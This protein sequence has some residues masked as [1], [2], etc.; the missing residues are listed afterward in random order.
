MTCNQDVSPG[1]MLT[2]SHTRSSSF[3]KKTLRRTK[4]TFLSSNLSF[5]L[6][7]LHLQAPLLLPSRP[8]RVVS[9]LKRKNKV[10]RF[11]LM[12]YDPQELSAKPLAAKLL[13]LTPVDDSFFELYITKLKLETFSVKDDTI[14]R[15]SVDTLVRLL[16]GEYSE[17]F[18]KVIIVDC[19]FEYEYQ[20]GHIDGSVNVSSQTQL[21]NEF[22][23]ERQNTSERTLMVFHCEFS[24]Y[25]G[26]FM[27]LH[28]RQ[29]DRIV[30][31]ENY[32]HLHYPNIVVLE[33]GYKSFFNLHAL[34][35]YPPRYVEMN[36]DKHKL[37]CER[38]LNRFRQ[39]RKKILTKTLLFCWL[40]SSRRG[41]VLLVGS[42]GSSGSSSP[43]SLP[44]LTPN[45]TFSQTSKLLNRHRRHNTMVLNNVFSLFDRSLDEDGPTLDDSPCAVRIRK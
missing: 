36:D 4:S 14:P 26:P 8:S 22:L 21:E 20:G 30:N 23:V 2:K 38:E 12:F 39:D 5:K 44:T 19:R 32:P 17:S 11:R 29:C 1:K 9:P 13:T 40:E 10:R 33:G 27:A 34:R 18:D 35:C 31:K 24:S 43:F 16:D 45:L 28:L 37:A 3:H 42:F 25:R 41:S 7:L 15:I 6:D